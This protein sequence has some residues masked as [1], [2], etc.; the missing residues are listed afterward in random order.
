LAGEAAD[1]QLHSL[2]G[3]RADEREM[4]AGAGVRIHYRGDDCRQPTKP[5]AARADRGVAGE[6]FGGVGPVL[7]RV[8]VAMWGANF[9]AVFSAVRILLGQ[10]AACASFG[11]IIVPCAMK[12]GTPC[13]WVLARDTTMLR[14]AQHEGL[15]RTFTLSLSKGTTQMA[16]VGLRQNAGRGSGRKSKRLHGAHY[17]PARARAG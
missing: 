8:L 6:R 1:W 10:S 7:Q 2:L 14:R 17:T 13:G 9:L 12:G 3:D 16:R 15:I 11:K 4:R 5:L